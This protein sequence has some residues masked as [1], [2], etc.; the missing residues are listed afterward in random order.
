MLHLTSGN[1]LDRRESTK[2]GNLKVA[3]RNDQGNLPVRKGEQ[4]LLPL[5]RGF[6]VGK[7]KKETG[8]F[9]VKNE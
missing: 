5:I 1:F 4:K 6:G 3:L 2:K 9:L 7:R 8:E